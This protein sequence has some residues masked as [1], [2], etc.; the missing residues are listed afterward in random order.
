MMARRCRRVGVRFGALR[1]GTV[2]VLA[3]T[4]LSATGCGFVEELM[5]MQPVEVVGY[6]PAADTV[7]PE[8]VGEVWVEFSA[9]MDRSQ[10]ENAFSMSENG[11]VVEGRFAW[12]RDGRRVT[13]TPGT[14][15][16]AARSYALR[17]VTQ[18][19]DL[20]GNS[21][22]RELNQLFS[23]GTE[24]VPPQVL[25]FSPPD[26]TILTD[27]LTAL[28][29]EFSE[30]LDRES[31]YR[32]FSLTP[33]IAGAFAWSDGDARVR[34]TP[35]APY[36]PG[37]DYEA[38]LEPDATDTSGNALVGSVVVG[39]RF[40][41]E[42]EIEVVSVERVSDGATL[43]EE[44][45]TFLNPLAVEKDDRFRVTFNRSVPVERRP[46]ILGITPSVSEQ[47]TWEGD[48]SSVLLTPGEAM[49]WMEVYELEAVEGRYRFRITGEG[50]RPP[51]VEAAYFTPTLSGGSFALLSL[52]DNVDFVTSSDAAVDII[53]SH[54][55]EATLLL[56]SAMEAVDIGVSQGAPISFSTRDVE[57]R[58][59]H[60][61][62]GALP[63]GRTAI[64]LLLSVDADVPGGGIVTLRM[65]SELKD[66][67]S[68]SLPEEWSLEVN[69]F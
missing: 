10:T 40:P 47:P 50:S 9:E 12:S 51:L 15:I 7:L 27:P 69:G 19:E 28:E 59:E 36:A 21:L 3:T 16:R 14:P 41:A 22:D 20:F 66:S 62:R 1:C 25:S 53:V 57:L 42:E 30:P 8:A 54:S 49:V 23:T 38:R 6:Y 31:F 37:A 32:G 65:G 63:P 56:A 24:G 61:L 26:G 46:G 11:A 68:N 43:S 4:V 67:R 55:V 48:G 45:V 60:P 34:F 39:F 64:R 18:A 17:V 2:L 44:S 58:G 33:E 35:V 52:G 5:N 29:I 13:F